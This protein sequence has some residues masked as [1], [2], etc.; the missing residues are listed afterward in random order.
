MAFMWFPSD[1]LVRN[2]FF[3]GELEGSTITTE[4]SIDL[5]V[6]FILLSTTVVG[7]PLDSTV[8]GDVTVVGGWVVV[9]VGDTKGRNVALP[10]GKK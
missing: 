9:G 6:L 7:M 5:P 3:E 10:R 4:L 8:S 2:S 1:L